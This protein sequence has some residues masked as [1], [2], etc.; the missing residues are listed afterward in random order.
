MNA[1]FDSFIQI[2]LQIT[3]QTSYIIYEDHIYLNIII[4]CSQYYCTVVYT[5]IIYIEQYFVM[6]H[7]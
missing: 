2:D 1:A 3:V 4:L 6:E 7:H 5:L